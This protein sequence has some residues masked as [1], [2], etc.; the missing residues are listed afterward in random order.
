MEV[1]KRFLISIALLLGMSAFF[2]SCNKDNGGSESNYSKLIVGSWE[3]A[4]YESYLNGK[5]VES[6]IGNGEIAVFT[7]KG[8][9]YNKMS[10]NFIGD[11]S[12]SGNK[13][14]I[15]ILITT[16]ATILKL[17]NTEMILEETAINSVFS[18]DKP[19]DKAIITFKRVE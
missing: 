9:F 3:Q 13:L 6:E 4:W 12:I 14:T 7:E 17:T 10:P 16:T 18:G 8:K 19:I 2:I 11:Y 5:I 15:S 1:M